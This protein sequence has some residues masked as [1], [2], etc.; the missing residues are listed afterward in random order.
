MNQ[1]KTLLSIENMDEG[2]RV[3]LHTE[4]PDDMYSLVVA[5]AKLMYDHPVLMV[6]ILSTLK[7]LT[8]N[9]ELNDEIDR[10]TVDLRQ[11]DNLLKN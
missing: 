1:E 2:T 9:D 10:G 4:N 3:S 6:G 8:E 5:I 7:E 11:F